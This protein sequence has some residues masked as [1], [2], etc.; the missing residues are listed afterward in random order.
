MRGIGRVLFIRR[1]IFPCVVFGCLFSFLVLPLSVS[2]AEHIYVDQANGVNSSGTTGSVADPYK[3]ITYALGASEYRGLPGPWVVHVKAGVYDSDPSKPANEREMFPIEL[4]DGMTIIGEDGADSCIISGAY[5][6]NSQS[7]L[8]R[9]QDVDN[10]SLKNLM[11]R[12]NNRGSGN[13]GGAELIDSYGEIT[14]CRIE[15]NDAGRG[16]GAW[17][18][19]GPWKIK[20]TLFYQ[21]TSGWSPNGSAGGGVCF[22]V[23]LSLELLDNTFIDNSGWS[24]GGGVYIGGSGSSGTIMGNTFFRNQLEN[25]EISGVG[26]YL[27]SFSGDISNN[28]FVSNQGAGIYAEVITGSVEGNILSGN[29]GS[30]FYTYGENIDPSKTVISNNFWLYNGSSNPDFDMNLGAGIYAYSA[31]TMVNNTFYGNATDA[32]AYG[33]YLDHEYGAHSVIK[34]NLFSNLHTAIYEEGEQN[35]IL[36]HNNFSDLTN[37]LI[38][39]NNEWGSEAFFVDMM[40]DNASDNSDWS[41][42]VTGE[43]LDTGQWTEGPVYDPVNNWTVLTDIAKA[44]IEGQWSGAFVNVTDTTARR[45]HFKI[46]GNTATQIMVKGNLESVD[47]LGGGKLY[48]IDDYRLSAESRNIDAGTFVNLDNDFEEDMRPQ[49]GTFDIGADEKTGEGVPVNPVIYTSAGPNGL[50]SPSGKVTINTGQSQTFTIN[51]NPNYKIVDVRVDGQSVG[52]VSSYTFSNVLSSGHTIFAEFSLLS[53]AKEIHIHVDQASGFNHP[54][55]SGTPAYPYKS[56]TYALG[57]SEYRGL[58]GPW[59]VHVK[60]GVYDSD[61]SKP[62][63]ERE[64]FPIELRDGMTIIG[65]DGADS[66]IISGAYA[67]NSQ[68]ALIRGQ[69]VDNVSLKN[70]MLRDNNRGSGNGGGAELIDSYGE[71]TG[72]RIE[73][74]DAGR[75]GGAWISGGPWK[76]KNTLFYQNT[77]G[78][79]PNGSAGGGVCFDVGLSLELLDNTFIDNSGWSLGGGV[80]IGGSGSSGTIMGNTFFRNQLENNEISGVGIYLSSFSGDISNNLFVSNQG[81]GIYAEV[82]TGSVEGNILSGNTGSAFYTYGENIDPSKTVISN[83]FWLYNGSSNP[84]FDMNLGAGIYAYSAVTMVNNTFYGN[85]TDAP[86][87]GVYLD[88]EYGA[89]S[90]IKNNLFSNLHTAIYEEG[91]QNPILSHNNFSDL[92][93]ILIRNNNEWGSEAFFVDMMVD[94]ASDNSDWSSGVTG[95]DL[96]TG[97]WTEG[98][99]YDPVNNWTVLTDIAKAWI[100]GQWSG[101]FVNVTDTT[102]RRIHF[103]IVGNTATQIMVKGNLES[104]DLL[105]GGKLYS[106]DDYRLSAES[107]NIDAGTFVNLDNDFEEDM[108]PQAGVFDIGADE[109][110]VGELSSF[111]LAAS[112][113]TGGSIF[114][115]GNI[116][117]TQGGTQQFAISASPGYFVAEVL[118]DGSRIGP[119]DSYTF[120]NVQ[121]SHTIMAEFSIILDAYTITAT[122]GAGGSISPSG[123]I[124]TDRGTDRTFT[125]TPAPGFTIQA[126]Y[127]DG[128][129][130]GSIETHSFIDIIADHSIHAVFDFTGEMQA[131]SITCNLS[132]TDLIVGQPL[133]VTGQI[134]PGPTQAGAFV[135]VEIIPSGGVAYHNSVIANVLGAFAYQLP[136]GLVNQAGQWTARA[137]WNGDEAL[138]GATSPERTFN[139]TKAGSR[140]SLH[141]T[142][143]AVKLGDLVTLT[144]KFTAEP[145]C[146]GGLEGRQIDLILTG[147]DGTQMVQRVETNDPWGHF[148]LEDIDGLNLLGQWTIQAD[149]AEDVGYTASSSEPVIVKVLE[150]AGY[151][152]IVQGKIQSQEGIDSH[153][154]TTDFVYRKLKERGLL[155]EDIQYFNYQTWRTGVD[156]AP[157]KAAVETAITEWARDKMNGQPANLYL[158]MVDHGLDDAFFIYPDTITAAELDGWLGALQASLTGQAAN[159]EIITLL[160]FCRSGS[161]IE[162]LSGPHR[163]VIASAAP[164]ESSYKGPK[165]SDGIRDGE[166]FVSEFF[167]SA[168]VGRPVSECFTLAARRIREFTKRSWGSVNGPFFDFSRQH[169]LLDDNSDGHGSHILFQENGDGVVGKGLFIGVSTI[170]GNDPEDVAITAVADT[171]YLSEEQNSRVLWAQVD[172]NSRVQSIWAEVKPPDYDP[173]DAGGSGQVEMDLAKTVGAWNSDTGRYE[174]SL[175]G[176]DAP[177]TYQIFYF[178]KDNNTGNVSQMMQTRVYKAEASNQAPGA[179]ALIEPIKDRET[180]T[181]VFFDWEDTTDPD[182]DLL[183]Y[184]LLISKADPAFSDPI[185]IEFLIHSHAL[186][187]EEDGIEDL[188]TY[189]WKIL[190]VDE[191]GAVS[192]SEVGSFHTDNTNPLYP[193]FLKGSVYDVLT[194]EVIPNATVVIDGVGTAIADSRG[195]FLTYLSA[196][197]Y[198]LTVQATGYFPVTKSNIGVPSGGVKTISPIAM[199]SMQVEAPV[200]SPSGGLY[201]TAQT[202]I[203]TC[204]TA[205]AVIRYTTDGT[206]PDAT[207]GQYTG[208]IEIDRSM[209]LSARAYVPGMEE[210]EITTAVFTITGS[211]A[212]PVFTP[213]PGTYPSSQQVVITCETEGTVIRYTLDGNQPDLSSTLYSGP[214]RLSTPTTLSAVAFLT[215]SAAS[216]ASIAVYDISVTLGDIDSD[217]DADLADVIRMMKIMV[218]INSGEEIQKEAALDSQQFGLKDVL[219]VI[220]ELSGN[221]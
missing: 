86:A 52:P 16:G 175:S 147:P 4:R 173:V 209:T 46:V 218:G 8:I 15:N 164:G 181:Q 137:T 27:S 107:R 152:I 24:L 41:S 219:H 190:A 193:G 7:A 145:D 125:I 47:L 211:V 45:I 178:A 81:A 208:L 106:I 63:N 25:N 42:G 102:A 197:T 133:S 187:G 158:I 91:E 174:W 166:Y 98:P 33:V 150:T 38:R 162:N 56:I 151:A 68:S 131:S 1:I 206:E 141:A 139:V 136:C 128:L 155:D 97:Q 114:P 201:T 30:A 6:A 83:N 110:F 11:L 78:W 202:A 99:V 85:A 95:E 142:S 144:G 153:S 17:I 156:A 132:D 73:N 61:P 135:D 140:V 9:G 130:A 101:A 67:A 28:L 182:D 105:G 10:V 184:T 79:S 69:D 121:G 80:Y 3:S 53:T 122:S 168:S 88:H 203:I 71:I 2:A 189:Y 37:I 48:S 64:M 109:F 220:Q 18:S 20:N 170:T 148:L 90:V 179:A 177:G 43:D 65:E 154:K 196:G 169:P 212:A 157:E 77:S 94:N 57:A 205:E 36:S 146:S 163:L 108:R 198:D 176:F 54:Q 34:N 75:G 74:N 221:R 31:V 5:A 50:I 103:K 113:G 70:L 199:D 134:T 40:V 165:D 171:I 149:F 215:D 39:N 192:E 210:S 100:E 124:Q 35:P 44:W 116:A 126:V 119:T 76:I 62:A 214:I 96:D 194:S 180:L 60:A 111:T 51:P 118:I 92:T 115:S 172:N 160:G 188:S 55:E 29:T 14:G 72:C 89:H 200:I 123:S 159:Q 143:N 117:V 87:Y 49:N 183:T 104:V 167:K 191:A 207:S 66:C 23:G 13:G 186:L 213:P 138:H 22:D 217:G 127:I 195:E 82:I 26:I 112:A 59:V 120:T 32:P 161:F 204:S 93:N 19:G 129:F 216:Q 185:S 58:P 12:D 84:D 21:N